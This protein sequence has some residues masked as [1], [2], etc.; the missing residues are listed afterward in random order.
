[1]VSEVEC[2]VADEAWLTALETLVF[3]QRFSSVSLVGPF[4][5]VLNHLQFKLLSA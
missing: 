2:F 5:L 4:S 1:V 3:H